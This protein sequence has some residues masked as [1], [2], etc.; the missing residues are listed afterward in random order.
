L[1]AAGHTPTLAENWAEQ[2]TAWQQAD[3]AAID[4]FA[5]ALARTWRRVT[6]NDPGR[7]R[8]RPLV[9]AAASWVEHRR[10]RT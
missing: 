8:I 2:T 4:L 9:D 10:A 7:A 5:L 3:P 6:E 1:I